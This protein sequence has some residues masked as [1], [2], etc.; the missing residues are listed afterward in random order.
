MGSHSHQR[1]KLQAPPQK[2]FGVALGSLRLPSVLGPLTSE[3]DFIHTV[4]SS[5][6]EI[7]RRH[8]WTL[9]TRLQGAPNVPAVGAFKLHQISSLFDP[10]DP[11][12][13]ISPTDGPKT[14]PGLRPTRA[15]PE[16][17][18]GCRAL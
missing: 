18:G 1:C 15:E 8:G 6:V 17:G 10:G 5:I 11:H 3:P 13:P 12:P 16:R 2:V 7:L 14:S 4:C 9:R